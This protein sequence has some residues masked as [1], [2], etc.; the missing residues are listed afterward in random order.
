MVC[1]SAV[2]WQIILE[3]RK[4]AA[5]ISPVWIILGSSLGGLLLLALLVLALW[6]V[7]I[8]THTHGW[9]N[10]NPMSVQHFV[11]SSASSAD[12]G[13]RKRRSLKPTGRRRRSCR[14]HVSVVLTARCYGEV[15]GQM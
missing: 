7:K 6:K 8:H 1:W 4:E 11:L 12:E 2:C 13:L 5:H 10:Q 15:R 9:R 3:I 14:S